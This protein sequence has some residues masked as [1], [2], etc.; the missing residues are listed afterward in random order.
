MSP[1][2]P[3]PLLIFAGAVG[4]AL[5]LPRVEQPTSALWRMAEAFAV[6][7]LTCLGFA[8]AWALWWWVEQRW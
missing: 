4:F 1:L 5:A 6:G 8:A 3:T 7:V 2:L